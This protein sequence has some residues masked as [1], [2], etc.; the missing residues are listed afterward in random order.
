[1]ADLTWSIEKIV[2]CKGRDITSGGWVT[3]TPTNGVGDTHA[4][5]SVE[6]STMYND[7]ET[8][9]ITISTGT[10]EKKYVTINRCNP[11]CNCDAIDF[12]PEDMSIPVQEDGGTVK[13][14]TYTMKYGCTDAYMGIVN[15]KSAC[16][17]NITNGTVYAV[18]GKNP[19]ITSD[20]D[21]EYYI[22][23]NGEKCYGDG[24][25]PYKGNFVQNK[26][27][28]PC[29]KETICPTVLNT[30]TR[31]SYESTTVEFQ[32]EGFTSCWTFE[33][34]GEYSGYKD[35]ELISIN[36]NWATIRIGE[37]SS[38]D[39]ERPLMFTFTFLNEYNSKIC[40]IDTETIMQGTKPV[41]I[42]CDDCSVVNTD[43]LTVYNPIPY[44]YPQ[45]GTKQLA[46]FTVN[47]ECPSLNFWFSSNSNNIIKNASKIGVSQSG[48]KYT[49]L[50]NYGGTGG[51]I[52][53]NDTTIERSQDILCGVKGSSNACLTIRLTQSGKPDTPTPVGCEC[54]ITNFEYTKNV[55][56]S[57]KATLLIHNLTDNGLC[58]GS[59][60]AS[61]PGAYVKYNYNGGTM[62]KACQYPELKTNGGVLFTI[63]ESGFDI[64]T[65]GVISVQLAGCTESTKSIN[66]EGC[67]INVSCDY[68][69]NGTLKG[70][71][72]YDVKDSGNNVVASYTLNNTEV[73]DRYV[74][75]KIP[76]GQSSD[77]FK[78]E[79]VPTSS[80]Y[81]GNNWNFD[82]AKNVKCGDYVKI[83]IYRDNKITVRA[84]LFDVTG[85]S[86][87]SDPGHYLDPSSFKLKVT[88]SSD[89][90]INQTI[91]YSIYFNMYTRTCTTPAPVIRESGMY[92]VK[93]TT[94]S[95]NIVK[96]A[97]SQKLYSFAFALAMNDLT[98]KNQISRIENIN[99]SGC[100]KIG[101]K[102]YN[103]NTHEFYTI[104]FTKDIQQEC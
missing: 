42:T 67:T 83:H 27:T 104:V 71:L 81:I 62:S 99:I 18:V 13:V 89:S 85:R 52:N 31:I 94:A 69:A 34:V 100:E 86:E 6:P 5:I 22:T 38:T 60:P 63:A 72:K 40:N 96:T 47:S 75:I 53:D 91:Y 29:E 55:D 10:G 66:E 101:D 45:N 39:D 26:S 76:G 80:Y 50:A 44:T 24:G 35:Y 33:G 41:I 25:K 88:T 49:V 58:N 36:E 48:N 59:N 78:V 17:Y 28:D 79:A 64:G 57:G 43:S 11:Q 103:P 12:K 16:D 82:E 73:I 20:R 7:C 56:S 2:D 97:Y 46:D 30:V 9:T 14:A 95:G 32:I 19:S 1:M 65:L 37:N 84:C 51:I 93:G 4:S 61:I 77:V 54:R 70:G 68:S 15:T 87:C 92:E 98:Y 3:V 102:Y 21:F 74:T 90:P 23:Y 8:A